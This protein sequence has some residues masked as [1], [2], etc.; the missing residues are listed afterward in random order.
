MKLFLGF[1]QFELRV[2][3]SCNCGGLHRVESVVVREQTVGSKKREREVQVGEEFRIPELLP[4]VRKIVLAI[5]QRREPHGKLVSRE[6]KT[7]TFAN[8]KR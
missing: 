3:G 1:V 6:L 8:G 4:L 5:S 7:V 2:C